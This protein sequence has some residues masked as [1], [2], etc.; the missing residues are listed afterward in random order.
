M[1]VIEVRATPSTVWRCEGCGS[2]ILADESIIHFLDPNGKLGAVN[3]PRAIRAD[4]PALLRSAPSRY[5]QA[6]DMHQ[7]ACAGLM[8]PKVQVT[9]RL[10]NAHGCAMWT[11]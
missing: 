5:R 10:V 1:A 6:F 8:A 4:V 2:T 3:M 9:F 7:S 11:W